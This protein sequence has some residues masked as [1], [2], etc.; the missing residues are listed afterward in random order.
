MRAKELTLALLWR[1]QSGYPLRYACDSNVR[2]PQL[3]S[4]IGNAFAT[5]LAVVGAQAEGRADLT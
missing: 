4:H 3:S 1:R 2:T 5:A